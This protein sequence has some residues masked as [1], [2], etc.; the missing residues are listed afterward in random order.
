MR[1]PFNDESISD[2]TTHVGRI[3]VTDG[4]FSP[5]LADG[6]ALPVCKTMALAR[7]A[8]YAAD[9]DKRELRRLPE[10]GGRSE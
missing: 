7:A 5:S 10:Y 9:A 4:G 8:V 2:G 6:T 1:A 3:K